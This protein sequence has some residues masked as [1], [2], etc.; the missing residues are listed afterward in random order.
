MDAIPVGQHEEKL[1]RRKQEIVT[2]LERLRQQSE[3]L[4]GNRHFD[5]LD[6]AW[7]D[8]AA[9]TV[10]RLMELYRSELSG[11]E[12]ALGRI[13]NGTFGSCLACHRPI[14]ASRLKHLPQTE[15][16]RECGDFRER[17]EAAA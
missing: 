12:R 7:D 14:E 3:D 11:V 13:Q 2:V 1:Q 16:C 10:D 6:Q 5:W 15:F 17:F 4:T 9:R 8:S